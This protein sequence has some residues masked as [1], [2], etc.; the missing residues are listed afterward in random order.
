MAYVDL[1]PFAA[2]FCD[3]SEQGKLTPLNERV[4]T[5]QPETTEPTE[6][7]VSW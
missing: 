1:N 3:N 5:R 2:K 7:S 4:E 6:A